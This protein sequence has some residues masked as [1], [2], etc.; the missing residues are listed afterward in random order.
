MIHL[1]FTGTRKGMTDE[2]FDEAQSLIF[3]IMDSKRDNITAH[4]GDCIGADADFHRLVRH[5]GCEVHLH[6]P[7]DPKHRAF[8][9]YD[10]SEPEIPYIDRNHQIVES[11]QWM[12]ATPAEYHEVIRSGTWATIRYT[13]GCFKLDI[14]QVEKLAVIYPDGSTKFYGKKV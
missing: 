6:P 5:A 9:D 13:R 12:I 3:Q 2:Q 14:G 8:C 1:G 10:I 7:E 4:H 11:S